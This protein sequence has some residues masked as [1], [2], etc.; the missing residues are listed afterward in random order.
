VCVRVCVCVCEC[1]CVCVYVC[2][3]MCA[4]V[5]VNQGGCCE[6]ARGIAFVFI[7]I[8]YLRLYL[9]F[10]CLCV[11][12]RAQI[13]NP[14]DCCETAREGSGITRQFINISI[15]AYVHASAYQCMTMHLICDT[16]TFRTLWA[17]GLT[18]ERVWM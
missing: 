13:L 14:G 11:Y 15:H 16:E 10:V 2:A 17:Y 8:F 9:M 12:V 5:C 6:A 4:C 7:C 3:C 18:N 1:A